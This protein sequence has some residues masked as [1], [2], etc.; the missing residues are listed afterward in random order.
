MSCFDNDLDLSVIRRLY[1][2]WLDVNK[3]QGEFPYIL[4]EE[5]HM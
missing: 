1:H 5:G 4:Y 3:L 2:L